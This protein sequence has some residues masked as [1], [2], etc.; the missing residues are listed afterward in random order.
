MLYEFVKLRHQRN[1][2]NCKKWTL[3][4]RGF[5]Y[6]LLN[7]C[8]HN[9]YHGQISITK[10]MGYTNQILCELLNVSEAQLKENLQFFQIQEEILVDQQ[11][12]LYL[13]HWEQEQVKEDSIKRQERRL[14][15]KRI[16]TDLYEP[17]RTK[18]TLSSVSIEQEQK[19][20]AEAQQEKEKNVVVSSFSS[21]D[22]NSKESLLRLLCA[23]GVTQTTAENLVNKYSAETIHN[24]INWLPYRNAENKAAFLIKAI[25]NNYAMPQKIIDDNKKMIP[26]KRLKEEQRT[27]LKPVDMR[28]ILKKIRHNSKLLSSNNS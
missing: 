1:Y 15:Q 26:F 27:A 24:Q 10:T 23:A 18:R 13:L 6:T 2:S 19:K 22:E 21:V 7:L 20:E 28:E 17:E 9:A 12:I 5:Y 3:E 4:Q 11:N 14:K 8:G 16:K 25:E